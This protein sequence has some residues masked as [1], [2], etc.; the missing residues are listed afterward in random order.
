MKRLVRATLALLGLGCAAALLTHLTGAPAAAVA[1]IP[2]SVTNTPL[3]VH[4]NNTAV[5]VSGTV[6]VS[7]FP[8]TQ[9]ITFS[10]TATTP[11][12]VDA[13]RSARNGF[14]AEC[15]TDNVDPTY[16]QAQCLLFSIPEGHQVVIE[17]LSCSAEFAAGD[18][19]GDVQLV[20]PNVPLGGGPLTYVHHRPTMTKQASGNGV[21]IWAS[22][23]QMRVYGSSPTGYGDQGVYAFFRANPSG[24]TQ[25]MFCHVSGYEVGQ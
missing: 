17:T 9:P 23:S 5:P 22:M 2:V 13:D 15:V 7:N 4:L 8:A 12:Y 18:G 16:G 19:P 20:V 21:D 10:N 14:N 25:D 24:V 1:P 11:V 3:P 6:A